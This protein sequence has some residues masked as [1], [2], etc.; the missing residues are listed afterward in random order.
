M[1]LSGMFSDKH[2]SYPLERVI[3]SMRF[4]FKRE[5]LDYVSPSFNMNKLM[6][7][8]ATLPLLLCLRLFAINF[9]ITL[10]GMRQILNPAIC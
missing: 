10:R 4:Q 1:I 5:S 9:F 3:E 8:S 2:N 7:I 6:V